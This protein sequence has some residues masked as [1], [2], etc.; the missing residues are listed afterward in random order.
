MSKN[1]H[2]LPGDNE[3]PEGCA[4]DVVVGLSQ[5]GKKKK[6]KH[7]IYQNFGNHT[8]RNQTKINSMKDFQY[9]VEHFHNIIPCSIQVSF[10][11]ITT[12]CSG[13]SI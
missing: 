6:Y 1:H 10:I 2:R 8:R 11:T 5:W 3:I 12:K 7:I 13:N 9:S 4:N